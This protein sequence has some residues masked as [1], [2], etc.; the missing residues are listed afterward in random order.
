MPPRSPE[1]KARNRVW[2][3]G[4]MRTYR[5][6]HP[7]RIQATEAKRDKEA[8]A[9]ARREARASGSEDY[10]AVLR[11]AYQKRKA[12]SRAETKAWKAANREAT[13]MHNRAAKAK[14][15]AAEG[16]YNKDDIARL[17][18][19]QGAR[20]LCGDELL[21]FHVDHIVPVARGGSNWPSNLQ[22]LCGRCN[23][24]KGAKTMAQWLTP[25]A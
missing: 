1:A 12:K 3:A 14:R 15:R 17:F 10:K 11:R 21:A 7:D 23:R 22:L 8:R 16:S 4:W 2:R 9:K 20:C 25:V 19:A 13:S 5:R 6:K 24:S 18:I